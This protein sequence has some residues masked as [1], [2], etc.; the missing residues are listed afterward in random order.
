MT[1]N[2]LVLF[3]GI[4]TFAVALYFF[5]PESYVHRSTP[6][7]LHV[8][9]LPDQDVQDLRDRYDP[10]LEYLVAET[11][12]EFK[13]VVP[14]NYGEL[15]RLFGEGAIDLAYLGGF[16]F[17]QAHSRYHAEP[18]VMR[19]VDMR[20]TSLFLTSGNNSSRDL[21]A[22][23]GKVFSFGS[24][25]S[26]SGHLMPR[27]FMQSKKQ[28]IPEKF[29][30]RVIFSGAHDQTA[31]RIRDGVADLGVA[32][33]EII[34]AM[35]GDGR[36]QKNDLH[37]IWETPPYPDYVWSVKHNLTEDVKNKI[38]DAFLGLGIDRV[39]HAGILSGMGTKAFFPT[40]IND[41]SSLKDVA[42]S[43]GFLDPSIQ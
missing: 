15:V 12:L 27:H 8:G 26:T 19:D 28:I 31:Y 4:C 2:W 3:T 40:G 14:A 7:I 6:L 18:L 17:L 36:L 5:P 11:G 1:K 16:T 22:F 30:S 35:I 37:I 32:N 39:D 21:K 38:R 34:R 29:F 43:L 41:F 24:K 25:Y 23:E 9:V 33:A 20:F 42:D 13:L 10:L